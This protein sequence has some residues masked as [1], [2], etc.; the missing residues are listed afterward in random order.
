MLNGGGEVA[1]EIDPAPPVSSSHS[2]TELQ[3]VRRQ[4]QAMDVDV[5]PDHI[6]KVLAFGKDL[7]QLYST[8]EGDGDGKLKVL[9]QASLVWLVAWCSVVRVHS[10]E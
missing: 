6:R 3:E 8:L 9:L 5:N 10:N 7:Q 1:M 4:P 2:R